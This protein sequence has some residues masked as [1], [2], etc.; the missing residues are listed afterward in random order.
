[1]VQ[2]RLA[3]V[4]RVASSRKAREREE[5]K[6]QIK[7][8]GNEAQMGKT[9]PPA[10]ALDRISHP[11]IL[12]HLPSPFPAALSCKQCIITYQQTNQ[13]SSH[14]FRVQRT[15]FLTVCFLRGS[16]ARQPSCCWKTVHLPDDNA[17]V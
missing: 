9:G 15:V 12:H 14:N 5:L 7:G 1:M 6:L 4:Q 17:Y 13:V 2:S 10:A 3:T 16:T 8:K 11:G